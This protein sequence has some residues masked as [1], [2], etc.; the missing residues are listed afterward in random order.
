MDN[1]NYCSELMV[2]WRHD[3]LYPSRAYSSL[4]GFGGCHCHDSGLLQ[5]TT[6]TRLRSWDPYAAFGLFCCIHKFVTAQLLLT[7]SAT[8]ALR[9]SCA[10]L[11]RN[12]WFLRGKGVAGSNPALSAN[13][14][15]LFSEY[16]RIAEEAHFSAQTGQFRDF[17]AS[18]REC[19]EGILAKASVFSPNAV[20]RCTFEK[21]TCA[22]NFIAFDWD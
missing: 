12:R 13:Q 9:K 21:N 22:Q 1:L 18:R 8:R 10:F 7:F 19:N 5:Q 16:R 3:T 20:P 17:K 15:S 2:S 4:A 14:S 6:Q 11:P